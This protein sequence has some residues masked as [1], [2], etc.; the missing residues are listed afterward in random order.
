M[1]DIIELVL[2]FV[3]GGGVALLTIDMKAEPWSMDPMALEKAF[4]LSRCQARRLR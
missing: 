1:H 3:M 4:S 2:V